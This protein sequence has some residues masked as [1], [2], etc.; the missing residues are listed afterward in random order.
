M[1]HETRTSLSM[2]RKDDIPHN[3]DLLSVL[4]GTEVLPLDQP[5]RLGLA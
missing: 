1:N 3:A 5:S 2:P 4:T